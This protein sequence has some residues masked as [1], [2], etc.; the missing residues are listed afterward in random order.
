M[1]KTKLSIGVFLVFLVGVFAGSLGMGMYLKHQIK[2]FEPG[3]PPPLVR[4]GFIMKRLSRDLD[5]TETQRVEIEKI[6]EESET[7][8]FA[9]RRQYLPEIKKIADQS[10]ALMKDKLDAE[11]QEKLEELHERLKNRHARA[12]IHS[13]PTEKTAEQIL[14]KMKKPLNLT[15]EQEAKLRPII[16]TSVEERRKIVEKYKEQDR[17]AFFS[18]K[19]DMYELQESIEKRLGEILEEKQMEE[20]R[21]IREEKCFEMRREKG[22]PRFG[23]FD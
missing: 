6:V 1:N 4:H 23:P 14:Y 9:I 22:K 17:P 21:K 13:I 2:K 7:K 19:R 15:N 10:F 8:I 16:E 3:G 20:Y 11:Q 12:F 5:L 18:L